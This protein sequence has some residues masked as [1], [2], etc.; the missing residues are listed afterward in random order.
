MGPMMLIGLGY[1]GWPAPATSW[2]WWPFVGMACALVLMRSGMR[3]K[4]GLG[5]IAATIAAGPLFATS[6]HRWG[7]LW[8]LG[9]VVLAW[10]GLAFAHRPSAGERGPG[11]V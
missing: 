1:P 2:D 4:F 7:V 8:C 3:L 11:A 6:V 9:S 5:M 10:G